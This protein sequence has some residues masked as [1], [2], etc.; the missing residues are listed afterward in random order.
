MDAPRQDVE[1]K[2]TRSVGPDW[3]S[4][5]RV[6]ASGS[7]PC[8]CES[9]APGIRIQKAGV[10]GVLDLSAAISCVPGASGP[11]NDVASCKGF[12]ERPA[13][14]VNA[15]G[16]RP[17]LSRRRELHLP[18]AAGVHPCAFNV[19]MGGGGRGTQARHAPCR[20]GAGLAT[21]EHGL[22]TL[23]GTRGVVIRWPG[24]TGKR[25]AQ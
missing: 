6:K 21:F 8:R 25:G 1:H 3:F 16:R 7:R 20:H 23:V 13:R 4:P 10:E 2:A 12:C 19:M 22:D 14:S 17:D 24:A 18:S 11:E 5:S 9:T 15:P